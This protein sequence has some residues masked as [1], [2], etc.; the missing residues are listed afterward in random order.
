[1][2][3]FLHAFF[4]GCLSVCCCASLLWMNSSAHAAETE[5]LQLTPDEESRLD[6]FLLNMQSRVGPEA[7]KIRKVA[8]AMA[9][10]VS[11]PLA[12][13]SFPGDIDFPT[14]PID[15]Q[16]WDPT[17]MGTG[18]FQPFPSTS[19]AGSSERV[20]LE[21]LFQTFTFYGVVHIVEKKNTQVDFKVIKSKYNYFTD[22]T[23]LDVAYAIREFARYLSAHLC[24]QAT[25]ENFYRAFAQ[26]PAEEIGLR[27][28][29]DMAWALLG[30]S[31]PRDANQVMK[32]GTRWKALDQILS[33]TTTF[34]PS[35]GGLDG[36]TGSVNAQLKELKGW[37]TSMRDV[38]NVL[39]RLN[40]LLCYVDIRPSPKDELKK[41]IVVGKIL[42]MARRLA[43]RYS[44]YKELLDQVTKQ[45][46]LEQLTSIRNKN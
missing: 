23:K 4:R 24:G 11:R 31:L 12:S 7:H 38:V 6:Q 28:K 16:P 30:N 14:D 39:T 43:E 2:S 32:L 17:G 27:F 40:K 33:T 35:G 46:K 1:M 22:I 25:M 21:V 8:L 9:D 20:A 41:R 26:V 37:T 42:E 29:Y 45:G 34:R 44:E 36:S 10:D 15:Q 13:S 19:R 18:D 5:E 3:G